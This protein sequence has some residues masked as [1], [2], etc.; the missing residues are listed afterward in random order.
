MLKVKTLLYKIVTSGN[1]FLSKKLVFA[2]ILISL[3]FPISLYADAQYN[4]SIDNSKLISD[5]IYEFD[6]VIK[7]NYEAITLTSYQASLGF[8]QE[9]INGGEVSFSYIEGTSELS[10]IPSIGIGINLTDGIPKLTFASSPGEDLINSDFIRIGHFRLQNTNSFS[11]TPSVRLNFDGKIAT[12][13]TGSNFVD[14]TNLSN[15]ST[16]GTEGEEKQENIPEE[17]VLSQNCPNPFNPSTSIEFEIK[18]DGKIKLAVFNLLGEEVAELVNGDIN[19]GVHKVDFNGVNLASGVYVYRL[20]AGNEFTE[21]K[22]MV[23]MK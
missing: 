21:T 2:T 9:A 20:D 4:I 12:I 15:H 14:I 5:N 22:K 7:S 18:E 6:V 1:P 13:F 23:L 8:N 10:N 16:T 17:Y 3:F 19:A 11:G